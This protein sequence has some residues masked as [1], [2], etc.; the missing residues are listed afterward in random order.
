[1]LLG[2]CSGNSSSPQT[3]ETEVTTT[4]QTA[5]EETTTQTAQTTAEEVTTTEQ[6]TT[7]AP[8]TYPEP[9]A[10]L[11][12]VESMEKKLPVVNI[13]SDTGYADISRDDY[14]DCTISIDC[15]NAEGYE[16]FPETTARI[17]GRGN[18]TWKWQ[19]KP[20]KIKLDEKASVLG[21]DPA[22]EWVLLSNYADKSLMRNTV[23]FAMSDYLGSLCFT[24]HSIPV[25]LY[26]NGEF[27][28]VY[29]IG[30]QIEVKK[31][32]IEIAEDYESTDTGFLAEIGGVTNGVDEKYKDYF[33]TDSRLAEFILIKSPDT[34]KISTEQFSFISDCVN[35]AEKAIVSGDY[36][37]YINVDSFIDCWFITE[38]SFNL[39]SCFNR[40]CYIVRDQGGK[41]EMG[42]VWD[43]D[44]AFGNFSMD[45]G[46][47]YKWCI[48]GEAS[49]DAYIKTNWY[50]YLLSDKSFRERAS[51]RWNEVKDGLIYTALSTIDECYTNIKPSVDENFARWDILDSVVGY[52]REDVV[53]YNTFELQVEYLKQFIIKRSEWITNNIELE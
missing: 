5:A 11:P 35:E 53:N 10:E 9:S 47:D 6:I 20:Y 52:E 32:R 24:P 23:A 34:D 29:S 27:L 38:L 2:G 7:T 45:W 49:E 44:L 46:Y 4:A 26:Y 19:K 25:E 22:K 15:S 3:S 21:L 14:S 42:P 37:D 48:R 13:T 8:F 36:E 30:E 16:D 17:R 1:M 50:N 12:V 28:G 41:L 18:S 43:F 31:G 33:H 39:D 40:S 51:E